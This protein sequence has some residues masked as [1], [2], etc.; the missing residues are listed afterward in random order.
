[1]EQR[2]DVLPPS[3]RA[4]KRVGRGDSVL[5]GKVDP[6]PSNRRHCMSG[7]ADRQQPR[8]VPASQPVELHRQQVEV[9]DLIELGEVEVGRST[10]GNFVADRGDA[11]RLID[12]RRTL[13]DQKGTLQ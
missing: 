4:S 7:V 3:E 12:L 1:V 8:F 6:N 11:P 2:I 5:D 9:A 10:R 13:R